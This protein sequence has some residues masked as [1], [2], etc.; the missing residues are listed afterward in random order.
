MA[1]AHLYFFKGI[2]PNTASSLL[3]GAHNL[4]SETPAVGAKWDTINFVMSSGG[5]DVI[6][7]FGL[8]NEMKGLQTK[9]TTHNAGAI[10][11]AAILP[12]LA[13]ERRTAS[14]S[15]AFFFHQ[16]HWS[17]PSNNQLTM[18][19]ISDATA[20]LNR[21]DGMM[22]ETIA[23]HT[24]LTK[25]KVSK[26]MREGTSIDPPTAKEY[27]LIDEIEELSTPNTARTWIA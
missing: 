18:G 14:A 24:D 5:G 2:D 20:W 9:V 1:T 19:T 17:F 27:G 26:L 15:S 23:S 10:D 21:Y 8:Y 16:L 22:A 7:A 3:V 6:S 4:L 11:S 12:F 13:G 25:A